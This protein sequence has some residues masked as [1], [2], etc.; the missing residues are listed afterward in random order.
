M[1]A[2]LRL[3]IL[4][5]VI[6]SLIWPGLVSP[7]WANPTV[8][9]FISEIQGDVR[10]KRSEWND[11]QKADFG[12]D[13]QKADFGD[14]LNPSDQLELSPGA[15]ATVMCDNSRVW[16]VPAGKVSLVSDGCGPGQPRETRQNS[17]HRTR[18]SNQTI[19]YIISPRNTALLNDRPVL[20]WNAVEGATS[21][22][23]KVRGRDLDW[24]TETSDTEI[25]YSGSSLQPDSYYLV[26]VETDTGKSSKGEQGADLTFTLLDAQNAESVET[27]VSKL[28]QQPLTE[29]AEVLGLAYLYQHYDLKAEAIALLEGLLKGG[30]Q[31]AAVYQLLGDLYQQVGLSQQAKRRYLQALELVKGTENLERQAQAQFGLGQVE[32]SLRKQT[33]AI[34]WLTQAQTNYQKL[35]DRSKVKQVKQWIEDC[36]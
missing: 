34:E 6:L 36:Q 20:R 24:N 31:K 21:Y 15:S 28:K 26:I 25:E 30:S 9:N 29:E 1:P 35:G 33:Q 11:Y 13:Y 5:G 17:R 7:G 19:P 16:V 2:T 22:R 3:K 14:V 27:E 8:L 18:D 32:C 10:L 12:N 4:A 23:V